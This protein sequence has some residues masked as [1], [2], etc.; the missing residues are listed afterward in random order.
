MNFFLT[1]S[2]PGAALAALSLLASVPRSAAA[3]T[4]PLNPER[5]RW[6]EVRKDELREAIDPADLQIVVLL[7]VSDCSSSSA[8]NRTVVRKWHCAAMM[9][10]GSVPSLSAMNIVV[11]PEE[12]AS[13][14]VGETVR[15]FAEAGIPASAR[16]LLLVD[17]QIALRE[18]GGSY[19]NMSLA[20]ESVL[21]DRRDQRW[22]WQ[23]I[24]RYERY[25]SDKMKPEDVLSD[26]TN[27][28]KR[29]VLPPVL[30]RPK[31]MTP[32][33]RYAM[34]WVT[35]VEALEAPASDRA[36]V[37]LFN[38]YSKIGK[39]HEYSADDFEILADADVVDVKSRYES[40]AVIRL[41]LGTRSYLAFDL[42]PREYSLFMGVDG[43]KPL[44]LQAGRTTYV[45]YYRRLF[46]G[47]G[48]EEVSATDAAVLKSKGKHAVL[49]DRIETKYDHTPVRFVR[50]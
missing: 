31:T 15:K 11:V 32:S 23:A 9:R 5:A 45:R 42:Q 39:S 25:T 47:N 2:L 19:F 48:V 30:D 18:A 46:N 13:P 33:E 21:F 10:L 29:E 24:H 38:D 26:L 12:I 6:S 4:S 20:S 16:Y 41:A 50:D 1:R 8:N 43:R 22:R 49:E 17:W 35:P 28:F 36:R 34:T 14:S 40:P 44:K 7:P 3:E 37:V 27:L